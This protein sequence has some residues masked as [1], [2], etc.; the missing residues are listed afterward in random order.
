MT[1]ATSRAAGGKPRKSWIV[2][3]RAIAVNAVAPMIGRTQ[4]GV[5]MGRRGHPLGLVLQS[6]FLVGRHLDIGAF[7]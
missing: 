4:V 5:A 6:S 7:V 2:R 3:G 1:T